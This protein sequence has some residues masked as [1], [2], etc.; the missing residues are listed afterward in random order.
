[1]LEIKNITKMYGMSCNGRQVAY[2]GEFK[3][4]IKHREPHYVF[5][6]NKIGNGV[7]Y[8]REQDIVLK[9]EKNENG[10]YEMFCMGLKVATEI[11]L[12]MGD[13]IDPIILAEKIRDVLKTTQNYY[14]K[15]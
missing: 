6:F 9:R 3:Y 14:N 5:R 8:A 12:D 13:L 1:M 4:A 7:D 15:I 11:E 2:A 10:K